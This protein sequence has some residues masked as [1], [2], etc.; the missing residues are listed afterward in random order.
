[1]LSL[2]LALL[3]EKRRGELDCLSIPRT[4]AIDG[5]PLLNGVLRAS[6]VL[7]TC[8]ALSGACT[9]TMVSTTAE[10][11][12]LQPRIW[13]TPA[14]NG[15]LTFQV[16]RDLA[17]NALANRPSEPP[18]VLLIRLEQPLVPPERAVIG[19]RL[20][21]SAALELTPGF[22][23]QLVAR[24]WGYDGPAMCLVGDEDSDDCGFRKACEQTSHSVF[25]INLRGTGEK[26]E[27]EWNV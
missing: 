9:A 22:I 20:L 24:C 10:T 7:V 8:R 17:A 11:S 18:D 6:E 16:L 14:T 25:Q 3:I 15:P 27:I 4:K 23:P 26:R 2:A 21:P 19:G 12:R 13:K 1:L 5:R